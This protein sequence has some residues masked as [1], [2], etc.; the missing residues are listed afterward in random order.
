M[1]NFA[2]SSFGA[3][4]RHLPITSITLN[5]RWTS[6]DLD[7]SPSKAQWLWVADRLARLKIA[8]VSRS[9]YTG[10]LLQAEAVMRTMLTLSV[11]VV[12]LLGQCAWADAYKCIKNG[13]TSYQATPC[14]SSALAAGTVAIKPMTDEQKARAAEALQRVRA[15]EAAMHAEQERKSKEDNDRNLKAAADSALQL[16]A[17]LPAM[18]SVNPAQTPVIPSQ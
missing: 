17:D 16:K 9:Y 10:V 7:V 8:G 12:S 6:V 14:E 5:P 1:R 3:T 2:G 11:L 15:E 18:P 13:R 4:N